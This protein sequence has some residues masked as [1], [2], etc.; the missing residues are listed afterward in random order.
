M[1]NKLNNQAQDALDKI[2]N[3]L[4]KKE[5]RPEQIQMVQFIRRFL[6]Y[7]KD[8]G[9]AAVVEAGTG[10]GK[11]FAYLVAFCEHLK[12]LSTNQQSKLVIATNTIN[13]QE[14]L[15]KKDIPIIN[16]LY[17]GIRFEKAK[18]KNNYI[19]LRQL[20]EANN[21]NLF[22]NDKEVEEIKK[23]SDWVYNSE[24]G[25]RSDMDF[26]IDYNTWRSIASD[27]ASCY[28]NNC[29][30]HSECY[31]ERAKKRLKKADIIITNHA[32]VLADIQNNNL[33]EYSHILIDEAHN[34]ENN[35]LKAMTVEIS[36]QRLKSI[37]RKIN[38]TY[39]QAGLRRVKKITAMN[40][41]L[42]GIET[43]AQ[44]FLD[45]LP[46]G[47]IKTVIDPV[48]AELLITQLNAVI[49]ILK[50]ALSEEK[51]VIQNELSLV[52][53]AATKLSIEVRAFTFQELESYVYWSKN[54]KAFFAPTST[55]FLKSYWANKTSVLTSATINVA[56]SFKPFIW[57][58]NL[59]P[60]NTYSLK[61]NSPFNYKE[62]ALVYIPAEAISPKE[63]QYNEYLI[64]TIPEIIK[65]TQGKVFVLF[66]SYTT[67]NTVYEATESNLSGFKL[68]K[69]GQ[70]NK[71][72]LLQEFKTSDKSVLFG[73]DSFW[74]GVDEE[75][76]CV[77]ITKLPFA[78]PTD[79]IEEAR[80][81]ILKNAGKNPFMY[82][83]IP[84]CALKLKQGAGRLI[85]N[86]ENRGVIVICDPRINAKWGKPIVNT[87]PEMRWTDNIEVIDMYM[88]SSKIS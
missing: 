17:P 73:T 9:R 57:G 52:I 48:K 74:E 67:L 11:T 43:N 60:V 31:Y 32:M 45:S 56:G 71:D 66:T 50:S 8:P 58:L 44:E 25:D 3:K 53:E 26:D 77:I 2:V 82:K 86:S 38:N 84:A 34:F 61:L 59:N 1:K 62:N 21:G 54:G 24:T 7:A 22:F 46:E 87:L 75:L 65:K 30:Y 37:I 20:A 15:I 41:T 79:P 23:I 4:N 72:Y 49:D 27:T 83:S 18:G 19:C 12:S 63:G 88:P 33:P 78:V 70:G 14:Q 81:E 6:N 10:V 85:R 39:C 13:L 69:Q 47:R 16:K 42:Q 5:S 28:G 64:K 55:S 35:A 68:L 40:A 76:N 36:A 29:P 51:S 80:Y